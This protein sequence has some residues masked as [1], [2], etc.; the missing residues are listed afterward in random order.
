MHFPQFTAIAPYYDDLMQGVPYRHWAR[1]LER[2][3]DEW[4]ALPRR[5]LDLAC[6]TGNVTEILAERGYEAVGVDISAPMIEEARRK[7]AQKNLPIEYHV[8]NAA[9]LDL[10]GPPFD[11]CVSLFDSLNYILEPEALARAMARVYAHLRQDG[12]FIFDVNSVFALQNQ[13]FDQEN[14]SSREALR[15]D[16]RS[17]YDPETR[18]CRVKMRF[19]LRQPD[20]ADREFY[21]THLQ[22]A[23]EEVEL[24]EMLVRAGF[25]RIESYHAYTLRPVAPATDRIFFVAQRLA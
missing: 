19:L 6:G 23:Y 1:Y 7:A 4:N 8:Q 2:L 5:V 22:Y 10:P 16:W 14:L 13:F 12:L 17:E 25:D 11:L 21:E 18:I 3:L 24:R 15:Y 9:Q 20:G